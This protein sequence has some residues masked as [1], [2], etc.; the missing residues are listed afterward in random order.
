MFDVFRD[1]GREVERVK[2]R[3]LEELFESSSERK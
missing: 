1:L 3:R 2:F